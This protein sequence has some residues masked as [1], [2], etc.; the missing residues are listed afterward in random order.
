[1]D[2]SPT[3]TRATNR[4][5]AADA[6]L[7]RSI[8][9]YRAPATVDRGMRALTRAADHAKLW[10]GVAAALAATGRRRPRRAAARGLGS[11]AVASAIANQLGKRAVT[12]RR[13]SPANTPLA[14]L[15][16]RRPQSS[17]FPSGH[18][19]SAAAFAVGAALEMPSLAVPVGLVAGGVAFSRVYTGVHFPSDVLAGVAI[20]ATVAGLGQKLVPARHHEPT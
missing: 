17:S 1:M 13:P 4:I 11:L 15:P 9:G 14:R 10:V 19:A 3:L 12:R 6:E 8:A 20:G 5:A 7:M 16:H 18:S 2:V